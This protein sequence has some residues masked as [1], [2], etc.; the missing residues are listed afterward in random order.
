LSGDG[1]GITTPALPTLLGLT[2]AET[3]LP[4]LTPLLM[5]L[6]LPV[7]P[8][9]RLLQLQ[10]LLSLL[11]LLLLDFRFDLERTTKSFGET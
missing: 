8:V 11:A 4:L 3:L 7:L 5:S 2:V 9:P 6:P 10:P 1:I